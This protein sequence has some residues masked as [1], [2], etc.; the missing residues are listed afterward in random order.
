M[1]SG[2]VRIMAFQS[3][4]GKVFPERDVAFSTP[5]KNGV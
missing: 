4:L 5:V 3:H 1:E 2:N